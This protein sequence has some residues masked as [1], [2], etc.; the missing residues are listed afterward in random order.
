MELGD[1]FHR[2]RLVLKSSQVSTLDP[3]FMGRWDKGRRLAYAWRMLDR[4]PLDD[5]VTHQV[6]VSEAPTM[7]ETLDT[8]P[9]QCLQVV[10]TYPEDP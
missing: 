2:K 3:R 5:L 1:L 10:F 4:V 8:H 9:E 7:Y 6:P